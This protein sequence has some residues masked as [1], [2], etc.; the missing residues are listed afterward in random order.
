MTTVADYVGRRFDLLVL[1]GA[2]PVGDILLRQTL[3][4]QV[5]S[6]DICTGIQ[7]L[8]QRWVLE[9]LTIAES[10]RFLPRRG[11]S[12]LAQARQGT[13]RTELDIIQAFL[14]SS[15]AVTANLRGEETSAMADDERFDRADL[16]G[17][18]LAPGQFSLHID[19][20]SLAGTSRRVILPVDTVPLRL[21]A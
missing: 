2:E 14:I 3:F 11:C 12:F 5:S 7:K 9:F 8:C 20:Y 6:G 16:T 4:D 19:I 10:M 21:T 1:R 15:L 17:I 13:L 18:T